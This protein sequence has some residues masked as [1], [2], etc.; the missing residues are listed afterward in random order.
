MNTDLRLEQLQQFG[1]PGFQNKIKP[2]KKA[3]DARMAD[4]TP[5]SITQLSL[6]H[7]RERAK[8]SLDT[9]FEHK[10]KKGK[11]VLE[12]PAINVAFPT[13]PTLNRS[14][15]SDE[16][17]RL[18]TVKTLQDMAQSPRISSS[19]S[20]DA[21]TDL[22]SAMSDK[23]IPEARRRPSTYPDLGA[24]R[25]STARPTLLDV[26]QRSSSASISSLTTE[27]VAKLAV[28]SKHCS[29]NSP[30][31]QVP[32]SD[33]DDEGTDDDLNTESD[34]ETHA[35]EETL[36]YSANPAEED[37]GHHNLRSQFQN[38]ALRKRARAEIDDVEEDEVES[39]TSG[40]LADLE[41]GDQDRFE[42]NRGRPA[43]PSAE[44][45]KENGRLSKKARINSVKSHQDF[46]FPSVEMQSWEGKWNSSERQSDN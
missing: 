30:P 4:I 3:L 34:L 17:A 46:L 6:A 33:A 27:N 15:I 13:P 22:S 1:F 25:L 26:Q 29:R 7:D 16:V 35:D 19:G 18:I 43:L 24:E 42:R 10:I 8:R 12:D 44:G 31:I 39:G 38:V 5:L 45:E 9:T 36:E 23:A 20:S 11:Q 21:L 28:L 2:A 32:K 14:T 41:G 37:E 40:T